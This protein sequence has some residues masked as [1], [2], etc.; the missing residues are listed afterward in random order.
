VELDKVDRVDW[1]VVHRIGG[2][3]IATRPRRRKNGRLI[4]G[5]EKKEGRFNISRT[6]GGK[7]TGRDL[8]AVA[9]APARERLWER[10]PTGWTK[11]EKERPQAV[12]KGEKNPPGHGDPSQR[13]IRKEKTTTRMMT[14]EMEG[15]KKGGRFD[16][17][18]RHS[19]GGKGGGKE[20]FRP[21]PVRVLKH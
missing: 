9:D 10:P 7:R 3:S 11:S 1:G 19:R 21:S 8:P 14:I 20:R 13:Q 12:P 6:A 16:D 17:G 15:E 18:R 5:K 4:A 2:Y